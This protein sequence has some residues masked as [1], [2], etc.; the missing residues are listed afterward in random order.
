M[1]PAPPVTNSFTAA[2]ATG[3]T[4]RPLNR[5]SGARSAEGSDEVDLRVIA[6]H[7]AGG[8]GAGLRADDLDVLPEQRVG[9]PR[10]VP[11][12]TP[13]EHH[14]VLDLGVVDLAVVADRREGTDVAVDHPGEGAR[15]SVRP[16]GCARR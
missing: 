4:R 15:C 5:P 13:L 12:P 1:K 6:E 8:A 3:T 11:Y 10:H 7:Q 16:P 2:Q 14:R 9:E